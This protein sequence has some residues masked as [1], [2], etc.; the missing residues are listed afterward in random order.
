MKF[1]ELKPV[2]MRKLELKPVIMKKTLMKKMKIC[3]YLHYYDM[4]CLDL[5][6][7]VY[8]CHVYVRLG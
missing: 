3:L 4:L 7:M 6:S 1:L 2:I 5:L 8:L